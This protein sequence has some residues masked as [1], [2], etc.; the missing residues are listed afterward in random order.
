MIT[1]TY[2][3]LLEQ[4]LLATLLLGDPNSSVSQNYL[5][6]SLIRGV[7]VHRYM[8]QHKLDETSDL[9]ADPT[10]TLLFFGNCTRYLNAYPLVEGGYR[11]LPTPLA[12]F[13]RKKDELGAT[14]TLDVYNASHPD[15]DDDERH[16]FDHDDTA[17]LVDIPFCRLLS[18]QEV[19][20]YR[21]EPKHITLH[22]QRDRVKGRATRD[23]GAVFQYEALAENQWFSGAILLDQDDAADKLIELLELGNTA[24]LGRSRSANYGRVRI[25]SVVKTSAWREIEG[26]PSA[27][28]ASQPAALTLLSDTLLRDEQGHFVVTL[29]DT[30]LSEYLQ[31]KVRIVQSHSVT[32]PVQIGGFNRAW[33]LPLPQVAGLKTGSVIVFEPAATMDEQLIANLEWRGI[34]E[35]RNEGFG[36]VAFN[37]QTA[38]RPETVRAGN[39]FRPAP[40]TRQALSPVAQRMARQMALRLL[41]QQIDDGIQRFIRDRVLNTALG[42]MPANSQIGRVRVLVRRALNAKQPDI[43][44]VRSG[45]YAFKDTARDQ[46]LAAKIENLTLWKWL[47]DLLAEPSADI[48]DTSEPSVRDVWNKLAIEVDKLPTIGGYTAVLD[49]RLTRQTALRLI[50]AVLVAVSRKSRREREE[51]RP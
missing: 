25:D 24:W 4:P 16:T 10:C 39:L 33:Q 6:G 40:A 15:A 32:A 35:R 5:P 18:D 30:V 46:F 1:I 37:W 19:R 9:F 17:E 2:R 44:V 34:G 47:T 14:S 23:G 26:R 48:G 43:S 21:L 12:L 42:A 8:K 29:D 13:K 27:L 51:A 50:E 28:P 41:Q 38:L 20:L 45:I 7:L 49:D 3:L 11:A 31:V 22:V 36:R